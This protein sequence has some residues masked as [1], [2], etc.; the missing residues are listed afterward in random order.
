MSVR[1][2][3]NDCQV[4][5]RTTVDLIPA[6]RAGKRPD[7]L[8]GIAVY[9]VSSNENPYPP[10]PAVRS[11]I[12]EAGSQINRYPDPANQE[13]TQ[14]IADYHQVAPEQI[15]LGTGAVALCYQLALISSEPGTEVI[16]PWRSFEAYPIVTHVAGAD[17]VA[18]PLLADGRHDLTA[19]LGAINETTRLIFVCSPN[20][21]TGAVVSKADF[22]S[23]MDQVPAQV[24]VVLDEAYAEFDR[25]PDAEHGI[26]TT[27]K[28]PNLVVLRTFSKAY[29]LAG[30]RVGFAVGHPRVIEALNK[31]GLPF[32]VNV[33]ASVAAVASL[34][35]D[36]ELI[37]RVDQLVAERTRVVSALAAAGVAVAELG[38]V[39]ESQANF[40]W[41]ALGSRAA[42]VADLLESK[43]LTVRTFAGEGLRITIGEPEANDRLIEL[44]SILV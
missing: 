18:V 29:G 23:F 33:I 5:L 28:Y 8:E 43:G 40:I 19:M 32:G 16:F 35:D 34:A 3:G 42:A 22:E 1:S 15:A 24:L 2:E 44:A 20:N 7:P 30:L 4:T 27:A 39:A 26:E 36:S 25:N 37:D 10:L 31:V 17:P 12:A 6:Y 38:S 41:L 11:V 13:L 21:P 14:A 9:K